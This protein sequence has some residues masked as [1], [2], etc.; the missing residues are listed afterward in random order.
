M[1]SCGGHGV[2]KLGLKEVEK[3]WSKNKNGRI[4]VKEYSVV[5]QGLVCNSSEMTAIT[6]RP[7]GAKL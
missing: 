2:H 5:A 1:A 6:N 4:D 3:W 7:Q